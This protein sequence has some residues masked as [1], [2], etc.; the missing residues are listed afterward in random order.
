MEQAGVLA[1]V[2]GIFVINACRVAGLVELPEA[3]KGDGV[4][5]ANIIEFLIPKRP[6]SL[7]AK[8]KSKQEWK[9]F[10][11]LH[12]ENNW[13]GLPPIQDSQLR[14]TLV[15]LCDESPPDIDNIIKPIQDALIGLVYEDDSLIADVDSHRRFLSEPLDL[16]KLPVLLA[17]GVSRGEECVYVRVNQS[18][19]VEDYL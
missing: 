19:S 4:V 9:N 11:R 8:P 13:T 16:T 14:L 15:Y 6:V 3:A 5:S 7:Q 10:V 2:A 12:A 18:Q 1:F 17:E